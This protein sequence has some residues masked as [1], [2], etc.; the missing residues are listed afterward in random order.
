MA[1]RH[2]KCSCPRCATIWRMAQ[3]NIDR[4]RRDGGPFCPVCGEP[5]VVGDLV[6]TPE[7]SAQHAALCDRVAAEA[8]EPLNRAELKRRAEMRAHRA[9]MAKTRARVHTKGGG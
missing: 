4:A 5:S 1:S 2:V 7:Q 9:R 3:S 8:A 6:V